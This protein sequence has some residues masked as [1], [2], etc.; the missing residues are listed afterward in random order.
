ME[1]TKIQAQPRGRKGSREARKLRATGFVPAVVYGHKQDAA[2]IALPK[3]DLYNALKK[4]ARLFSLETGKTAENAFI[5][6]VQHHPITEEVIHVDFSRVD[7]NERISLEVPLKWHGTAIGVIHG[8]L[9]EEIRTHVRVQC[10]PMA[11]PN[12]VEVEIS[13]IDIG[14]AIYLRDVKLSEGV[15]LDDNADQMVVRVVEKAKEEVAAPAADAAAAI[16]AQP[17][18]ITKKKEEEEEE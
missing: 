8:G 13:G 12:H 9:Q 6:E 17:E 18:V 15:S 16:P 4:G 10:L 1:I 11:I 5:A 2:A 7:L 3:T 14:Q